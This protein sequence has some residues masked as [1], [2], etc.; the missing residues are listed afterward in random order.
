M[1]ALDSI[2]RLWAHAARS[3]AALL[4]AVRRG[5]A[6]AEAL[7]ELAHVLGAE[8]VWLAR[9]EGRPSKS[10]VWPEPALPQIDELIRETH[11]GFSRYLASLR[12]SDVDA[13]VTYT[14]SAGR[15]FTDLL[16]DILLHVMLHGQ[17]HRG[18]INLLLRGSGSTPVP[19][20]YIA[21][22]RGA[23]AATNRNPSTE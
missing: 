15:T 16:G 3:D 19:C 4:D 11:G 17:Y 14:N 20:D 22:V 8:E 6:P 21:F 1:T 10:A 7:R 9:L 2:R 12:D 5:N 18:K 23:A 13:P